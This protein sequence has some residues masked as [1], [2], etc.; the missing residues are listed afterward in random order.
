MTIYFIIHRLLIISPP[1][2]RKDMQYSSHKSWSTVSKALVLSKTPHRAHS[3]TH[4]AVLASSSSAAPSA[5]AK[6]TSDPTDVDN[7]QF[8]NPIGRPRTPHGSHL[9]RD[10]ERGKISSTMPA[11]VSRVIPIGFPFVS[12][13]P[14]GMWCVLWSSVPAGRSVRVWKVRIT[15]VRGRVD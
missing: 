1:G 9:G 15:V 8:Q 3:D 6:T 12:R 11:R 13:R 7:Y 14:E 10:F 4:I 2:I 5:A